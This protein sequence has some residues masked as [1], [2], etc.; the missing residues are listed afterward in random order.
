MIQL[1]EIFEFVGSKFLTGVSTEGMEGFVAGEV[2][3]EGKFF[4]EILKDALAGISAEGGQDSAAGFWVSQASAEIEQGSQ[5]LFIQQFKGDLSLEDYLDGLLN[6]LNDLIAHLGK[7]DR[8]GSKGI[9]DAIYELKGVLE[10]LREDSIPGNRI[11]SSEG[12]S[13][14]TQND[15]GETESSGVYGAQEFLL[16][17]VYL[18]ERFLQDSPNKQ[19]F[20]ETFQSKLHTS[21]IKTQQA[22]FNNGLLNE[23]Q[24]KSGLTVFKVDDKGSSDGI[25]FG[26]TPLIQNKRLS[27]VIEKAIE[28]I[29]RRL[30]KEGQFVE[31]EIGTQALRKIETPQKVSWVEVLSKEGDKNVDGQFYTA[32]SEKADFEGLRAKIV[33]DAAPPVKKDGIQE[34]TGNKGFS[35]IKSDYEIQEPR[36]SKE[37]LSEAVDG[38]RVLP[39]L[40]VEGAG[41][42]PDNTSRFQQGSDE[43]IEF[44]NPML[45]PGDFNGIKGKIGP[46]KE[47]APRKI[48]LNNAKIHHVSVPEQE[49]QENIDLKIIADDNAVQDLKDIVSSNQKDNIFNNDSRNHNEYQVKNGN[50]RD[51]DHLI[52]PVQSQAARHGLGKVPFVH[53]TDAEK[54]H[55]LEEETVGLVNKISKAIVQSIKRGENRLYLR[56]HPPELGRIHVDL[57]VDQTDNTVKATFVT[58]VKEVKGLLLQHHNILKETL[59]QSGFNLQ[60][61]SVDVSGHE[62]GANAQPQWSFHDHHR[63][64][65]DGSTKGQSWKTAKSKN[66]GQIQMNRAN[67]NGWT[68]GHGLSIRV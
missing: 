12:L 39:R 20:F 10:K 41:K 16:G 56:L 42:Q 24:S 43:T 54:T 14:Q 52:G 31:K 26:S 35:R 44:E 61:F 46:K 50:F 59:A 1:G 49:G 13:C 51:M 5:K 47:F 6:A 2:N 29:Q 65:S 11:C 22:D 66:T 38:D 48:F 32:G 28:E 63:G 62:S 3:T 37:G 7:A 45:E 19:A 15:D 34:E 57:K 27:D 55:V 30:S 67:L 21:P 58:E 9:L 8:E 53:V 40:R 4:V 25:F 18:L 60:E 17:I 64:N 68:Q 23:N 33:E 36:F